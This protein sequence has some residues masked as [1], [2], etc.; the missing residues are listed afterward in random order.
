[1]LRRRQTSGAVDDPFP[2][3]I[4]VVKHSVAA[5]DCLAVSNS[6]SR[7]LERIGGP[8]L[9]SGKGEFLTAAHVIVEMQKPER[10]CPT[11]ALILPDED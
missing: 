9:V 2:S 7:I 1:M 3:T 4:E 6:E 5:L 10:S 8:F 11:L